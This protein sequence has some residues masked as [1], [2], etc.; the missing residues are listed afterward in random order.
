MDTPSAKRRKT[1]SP[2]RSSYASYMSPT[3]A[4]LARYNPSLLTPRRRAQSTQV[5]PI[6][7]E[8]VRDNR[9]K[10]VDSDLL[11]LNGQG[12]ENEAGEDGTSRG[13]EES[14][15][16]A[17]NERSDEDEENVSSN[18]PRED[19][20]GNKAARAAIVDEDDDLPETPQKL[21][22]APEFQDTPPRGIF[23]STPR[24]RKLKRTNSG[25]KLEA[26]SEDVMDQTMDTVADPEKLRTEMPRQERDA[27]V[28][29]P[30]REMLQQLEDKRSE[31]KQMQE[32]LRN[33]RKDVH[34][35]EGQLQT[36]ETGTELGLND[37]SA[38]M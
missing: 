25:G 30:T 15:G 23:S 26:N 34:M 29:H 8:A 12:M 4:S 18:T 3:K 1:V 33:L 31:L 20:P 2:G 37:I 36:G 19:I 16:G 21:R 17:E 35:F 7:K 13:I 11:R 10:T 5:S 14:A 32:E 28:D 27:E 38:L 24:R 22:E 9:R 6:R